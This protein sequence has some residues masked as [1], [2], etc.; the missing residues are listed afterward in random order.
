LNVAQRIKTRGNDKS[1][2]QVCLKPFLERTVSD[3]TRETNARM[4]SVFG[5]LHKI[6]FELFC[7]SPGSVPTD[8]D[9]LV[10]RMVN[11][12]LGCQSLDDK[13][14]AEKMQ[15]YRG[16]VDTLTSLAH[17]PASVRPTLPER[18]RRRIDVLSH[19]AC[20]GQRG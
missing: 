13:A 20:F 18:G 15:A 7:L 2:H 8:M 1:W 4:G 16:A 5:I 6:L 3:F 11:G 14:F 19:L 17:A 10:F 12:R 9:E